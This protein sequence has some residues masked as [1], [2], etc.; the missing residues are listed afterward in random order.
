MQA[1]RRHYNA[2]RFSFNVASGRCPT[3]EGEGFVMVELL[4]LPSVYTPCPDCRGTR[5]KDST[6]QVT[7]R[8]RN[9][10][11]ILAMSVDQAHEF[12]A[13]QDD[14]LRPLTVLR[15]VGLG[16]LRLGQPATE[17]S[18]GEAQ[19]IHLAS[20]LGSLLSGTLYALDEPTVGLHAG[21]SRRLLGV[22]RHLRD[23]G[24]TVVVV[25][26]DPIMI[27]GADYVLPASE[28]LHLE[29]YESA[30][31]VPGAPPYVTGVVQVRGRGDIPYHERVRLSMDYIRNYT[32][33]LD[34]EMLLRTIPVVVQGKGAY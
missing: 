24:N 16:Y 7:W 28:V 26:H 25:E 8:D 19:R 13:G 10:A 18:G 2:G 17:L 20:A 6:L 23:L 1:R 5:Y 22:L 27:A 33:W 11:E 30:T 15:D 31:P 32:I 4:F 9:I 21:E 29:S 12:F 14:V 3:C 34:V